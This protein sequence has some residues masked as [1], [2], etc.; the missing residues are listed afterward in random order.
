MRWFFAV[1]LALWSS[2][3]TAA[4]IKVMILDGASAAAYHD[5]KL[6][7]Q[8][9]KRELEDA[10]L[11]DVTVVS[12]PPADG[13]FSNF[14]PDFA[15]YQVVVSNYDA[16]DWPAPLK[17]EFEAY[18][19]NGGGLVVV[20]G[21]DNAF[22]DWAAY[23][24][25]TGVGGWRK[26]DAAAGPQMV[27]PERQAH[28]RFRRRGPAGLHGR[29]KPF[30][31]TVRA[32]EHP[33]MRGLPPVW[34]HAPDELYT[35][36]RGPGK[37]MTVLATAYADPANRGTGFD[38]PM[39]MALRWG[40]GRIFH[41]TLGHDAHGAVLC[42]LHDH[43]PARRRMGGHGPRHPAGAQELSHRRYRQLSRR[44]GGDGPAVADGVLTTLP[45][46]GL[47]WLKCQL[48]PPPHQALWCASCTAAN[49]LNGGRADGRG[50]RILFAIGLLAA[51]PLAASAQQPAGV[52]HPTTERPA[53]CAPSM[54]LHFVCGLDEPEDL[55]QVGN[56][57]WVIASGMGEHGG[58]FLIDTEAK[59]ARRFF[60]GT[61][62]PDLKMYPDCASAPAN[63]NAHGI[64]LRPT[65][66]AG[67]YTLYSVTHVPF[68]SIQVF[69]VDGRGATPAISW[70]GCVKLPADF[71]SNAVTALS[72]GTILD[73]VQ[74]HDMP[75]ISSAAISPAG[76]GNGARRTSQCTCSRARNSRAIT[77]SRFR[78]TKKKSISPC[79]A[80]RRWRSMTW[81]TPR[82]R[83]AR[84]DALGTIWTIYTGAA[85]G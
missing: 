58:I 69:A 19:K 48:R 59:T 37:N 81:P 4:P 16:Q 60:T 26:R 67:I 57:K 42:G 24:E 52:P 44:S 53:S 13:D 70:T 43:L 77:A 50:M 65:K 83:R 11:F 61:S 1:L 75:P 2:A 20:H 28:L 82:N 5:W 25:M 78:T 10:S 17:A 6:T 46:P 40:K 56:S 27:F 80:P 85:T 7:T 14:H 30:R 18:M 47:R 23:N 36:L 3:A 35:R 73:D 63:L 45:K 51:L 38:E 64:A 55:L 34:M 22:P 72:D 74:M 68:E 66:M 29:R 79:P 71:K 84:S 21:A 33:I 49:L 54:G 15:S 12:A 62:K 8:V 31:I 32:P 9:M 41:T 76:C 39:L